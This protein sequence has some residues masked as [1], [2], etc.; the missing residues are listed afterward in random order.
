MIISKTTTLQETAKVDFYKD[1]KNTLTSKLW[2]FFD[3]PWFDI[4]KILQNN[5]NYNFC[6]KLVI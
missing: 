3:E 2:E 4:W 6:F 5:T 1:M